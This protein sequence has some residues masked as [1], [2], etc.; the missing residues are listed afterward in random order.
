M[1]VQEG[2]DFIA[3]AE[4]ATEFI[5]PS[6]G[7]TLIRMLASHRP[8]WFGIVGPSSSAEDDGDAAVFWTGLV[9]RSHWLHFSALSPP[10][11]GSMWAAEW[12]T[13]VYGLPRQS[14]RGARAHRVEEARIAAHNATLPSSRAVRQT[15]ARGGAARERLVLAAME[16]VL[17]ELA[18]EL[19]PTPTAPSGRTADEVEDALASV[20]GPP[21]PLPASSFSSPVSPAP[22][23]TPASSPPHPRPAAR[24]F[25]GERA[26]LEQLRAEWARRAAAVRAAGFSWSEL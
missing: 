17:D 18:L 13:R 16:H 11:L 1:A 14:P 23:S 19:G 20:L 9:H 8:P 2:A 3:W 4:E 24:V 15:D 22:A 5:T 10:E 26:D 21:P 7:F 12:L 25:A 6:W